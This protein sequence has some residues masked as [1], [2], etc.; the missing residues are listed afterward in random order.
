MN[1]TLRFYLIDDDEDDREL[2]RIALSGLD[3]P[4]HY[5]SAGS[6]CDALVALREAQV[7]PDVIFL[8]LNM[9][10]MTGKE[11]LQ[12]LKRSAELLHI[13]VVIFSTSKD[14]KDK[15]E[16]RTMGAIHF[17]TKPARTSELK[18]ILTQFIIQLTTQKP[19]TA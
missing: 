10:E 13:P 7:K 9:P 19:N 14:P 17:I 4:T 15:E 5:D 18:V 12:E 1:S 6:C 11:C 2:F 8:D 3:Y 16:T